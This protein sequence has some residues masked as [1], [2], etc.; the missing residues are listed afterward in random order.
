[1]VGIQADASAQLDDGKVIKRHFP[2]A[3]FWLKFLKYR[4]T[5]KGETEIRF[6]RDLVPS[7]CTAVDVGASLGFYAAEIARYASRVLAFEANPSVAAFARSVA[8]ANVDVVNAALSSTDGQAAL[9][10]PLNR[11]ARTTSELATI[12]PANT[13]SGQDAL[14]VTVQTRR[15]DDCAILNCGF[16]K[17]DVEGH[18]ERVID[19]GW[20]LISRD[21]PILLIEI[22]EA[23]NAGGLARIEKRLAPLSYRGYALIGGRLRPVADAD[24]AIHGDNVVFVPA[25]RTIP[26]L[27]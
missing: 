4:Y 9:R 11:K 27:L 22:S 7:G 24:P 15:L 20:Q 25:S 8:R 21:R 3:W 18:E 12:E 16:I 19:G 2:N 17:I 13:L 10:I 6:L 1:V 26:R 5:R 23:F 14:S